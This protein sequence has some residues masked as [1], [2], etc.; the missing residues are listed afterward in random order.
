MREY[1]II[2]LD[3]TSVSY[4]HFCNNRT[5]NK[6]ISIE[7]LKSGI[8]YAMKENLMIQYVLPNYE[9]PAKYKELMN[10][11]DSHLIVPA[12]C[13][14]GNAIDSADVI[15]FDE[16][17]T[18]LNWCFDKHQSYVL[19]TSKE[20]YFK[21]YTKLSIILGKSDRIGLVFTDVDRFVDADFERY[22]LSLETL[23]ATITAEYANG[24]FVQFN[25]LTDRMML[26]KMN[27][28]SAGVSNIT[29][30]PNGKFYICPAFYYDGDCDG[31]EVSLNDV[32]HKGYS[33]GSLKEGLLIKN[34]Q[35][36]KL[37]YAPICR[38]CDAYHCKRCVWLNRRITFEVNTP[39]H[40]QCVMAHIE[41]NAAR[42]L[43]ADIRD[44]GLFLPK[45]E[46]KEIDYLDP[47]DVI[48]EN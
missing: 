14:D 31:G 8:F 10:S 4:C 7:D 30:A 25:L 19:R 11:I 37:D 22:K 16:W 35:I 46:I 9:L 1:L 40:A 44:L 43:L 32:C 47:F 23:R 5:E 33:I 3:D 34:P 29:L 36:Y 45:Q 41:R 38:I 24:H 21:N 18:L 26:N 39:S 42:Q 12:S 2:L 13:A 17:N 6:L 20:D 48:K 27:N 15:V 28:C